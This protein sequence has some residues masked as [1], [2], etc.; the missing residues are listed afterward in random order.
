MA[1]ETSSDALLK[2]LDEIS[3][4]LQHLDSRDRWRMIG[5]T[6]RS[7]INVGFLVFAIWSSWYLLA[8]MGD[9]IKTVSEETAK[10]TV[11][12]GKSG[13]EDLMKQMQDLLK[14]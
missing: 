14:Q 5:G 1:T 2:K 13:S 4:H 11:Q 8:N 12:F 7:M 6:I 3:L 10:A 9:I